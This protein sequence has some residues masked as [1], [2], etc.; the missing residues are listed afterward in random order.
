MIDIG[1]GWQKKRGI[2][3]KKEK[4]LIKLYK[5]IHSNILAFPHQEWTL[6]FL[7]LFGF[8]HCRCS[9]VFESQPVTARRGWKGPLEVVRSN[10]L[11]RAG[12][13]DSALLGGAAGTQGGPGVH[14]QARLC[15][16][17]QDLCG[18]ITC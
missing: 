3:E 2:K 18:K 15:S 4:A 14:E 16:F 1:N 9:L 12:L 10:P 7:F 11:L 5:T 13:R 8:F 17:F 6:L